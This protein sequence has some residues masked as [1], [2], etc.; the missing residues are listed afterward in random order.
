MKRFENGRARF[1]SGDSD[2]RI[3][4]PTATKVAGP[5]NPCLRESTLTEIETFS[6]FSEFDCI[7]CQVDEY[8]PPRRSG[9]ATIWAQ[10]T[11]GR[12]CGKEA[13]ASF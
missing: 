6:L 7:P 9:S 1:S 10:G 5:Q 13:P 2:P 11:S 4:S 8:L 12:G 3:G